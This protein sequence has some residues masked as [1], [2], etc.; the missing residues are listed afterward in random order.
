MTTLVYDENRKSP[1][2]SDLIEK[3]NALVEANH[4]LVISIAKRYV[5]GHVL[6]EDLIQEGYL[7]LIAATE[8]FDAERGCQFSTYAVYWIRGYISRAARKAMNGGELLSLNMPVGEDENSTL[9]EFI[10][11][12][13]EASPY[14]AAEQ[15]EQIQFVAEMMSCLKPRERRVIEL[16]FG[17][18]S[19][20]EHSFEEVGGLLNL[21]KERVRQIEVKALERLREL[22]I[23]FHSV[24]PLC[25]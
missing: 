13:D 8:R 1:V 20:I 5:N 23:P 25:C 4:G 21:S 14:E 7:G 9:V 2:E 17:L 10:V 16:R 3:R 22:T 24:E 19:E 12:E 11:D 18:N 6:I 15:N